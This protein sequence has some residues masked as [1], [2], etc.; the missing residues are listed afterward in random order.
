MAAVGEALSTAG[1]S[2]LPGP[3]GPVEPSTS[4]GGKTGALKG[5]GKPSGSAGAAKSEKSSTS[6]QRHGIQKTMSK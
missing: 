6:Q 1:G 4:K 2:G 3:G 5:A